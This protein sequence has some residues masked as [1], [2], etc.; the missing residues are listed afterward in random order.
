MVAQGPSCKGGG[1]NGSWIPV[2]TPITD[3]IGADDD[4]KIC[5]IGQN[6]SGGIQ[7][8][9]D[10]A[11]HKWTQDSCSS[12]GTAGTWVRVPGD[13][14]YGTNDFCVMKYE[15]KDN[16]GVPVSEA[17]GEPWANINQLDAITE[18]ASIGS[19]YHL[20]TNDEWMTV[21]TN[22]AA[23]GSNW[24]SGSVGTGTLSNVKHNLRIDCLHSAA[25]YAT[26]RR[27]S[28]CYRCKVKTNAD[29]LLEHILEHN[30]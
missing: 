30:L 18:C 27:A 23:V 4:Y 1:Y 15:A 29:N 28:I 7:A 20:I 24:S 12:I 21:T 26:H 14:N 2:S 19:G 22:A 25:P 16:L 10:A 5:V 11:T 6:S 13:S 9:A 8:E 3:A 17:A